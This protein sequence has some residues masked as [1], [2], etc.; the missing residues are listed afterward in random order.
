MQAVG[1][2]TFTQAVLNVINIVTGVGL[3]SVP[4]ALKRAGWAGLGILWVLGFIMNYTGSP[5]AYVEMLV[6]K[7]DGSRDS[8]L[9]HVCGQISSRY[10]R[11]TLDY[12]LRSSSHTC[13]SLLGQDSS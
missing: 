6:P 7:G 10:L 12:L 13:A 3:L 2:A 9:A 8:Q 11:H 1:N 4:F 5:P